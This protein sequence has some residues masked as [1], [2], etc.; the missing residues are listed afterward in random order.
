MNAANARPQDWHPPQQDGLLR[1]QHMTTRNGWRS[2]SRGVE[3]KQ[4][5][6]FVSTAICHSLMQ[7]TG[8]TDDHLVI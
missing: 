7:A 8:M 5:F 3:R 1:C 6:R 4:G 2:S